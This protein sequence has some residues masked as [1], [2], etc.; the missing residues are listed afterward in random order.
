M[1]A[2]Y[3]CKKAPDAEKAEVSP[4]KESTEMAKPAGQPLK[5][6]TTKS[7]IKWIGTKVTGRHNGIVKIK[8]GEVIVDG[9]KITGGSFVLD[10]TTIQ[11]QSLEGELK[12][13]LETHLKDTDFFEVSKFPEA[14]FVIT[15]VEPQA[16][17]N[18]YKITGNLTMKD[19]TKGIS[20]TANINKNETKQ[21]V[22]ATAN[23][24]IDR[25]LWN[26]IYKGKADDLISNEINLDLDLKTAL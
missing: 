9:D 19:I 6:D 2:T 24:N 8:E 21:P 1:V 7:V 25:Q 13:K 4:E 14:K 12:Q 5:L 16:E 23:F 10:M 18:Q 17:A 3:N 15:S 11:D 20:F 26:I 22:S